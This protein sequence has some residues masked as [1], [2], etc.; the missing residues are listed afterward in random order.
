MEKSSE[1]NELTTGMDAMYPYTHIRFTA[2][3]GEDA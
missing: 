2:T 1:S 3:G